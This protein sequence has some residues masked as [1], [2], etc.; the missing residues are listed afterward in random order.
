MEY[1]HEEKG[2]A[3]HVRGPEMQQPLTQAFLPAGPCVFAVVV[4]C[5]SEYNSLY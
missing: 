1:D 3:L 5:T 4:P 2:D